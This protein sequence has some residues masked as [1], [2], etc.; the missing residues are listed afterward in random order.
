MTDLIL[1]HYPQSP[2]SEKVRIV[3][4][5]KQLV[6][7]SVEIP[8]LLPKPDLVV[9]TGGYRRTPVLQ[10][11]ADIYCDTQCI[12]RE[13][14]RRFPE[15]TLFPDGNES[16][17]WMLSRWIDDSLL[18]L[19]LALV[20][21]YEVEKMPPEFIADRGRLYFGPNHDLASFNKRL[22]DLESQL[23]PQLEWLQ[24]LLDGGSF[25]HGTA[26]GLV[27]AYVYFIVWFFR[28][29]YPAGEEILSRL[30]AL[31]KW[32]QNMRAFGHGSATELAADEAI[33][34]AKN[35]VSGVESYVDPDDPMGLQA[36]QAISVTPDGE[37]GD[38]S[39]YGDLARLDRHQ[40]A[41]SRRDPRID[42]VV[43]CFPRIGYRIDL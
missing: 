42:D 3:F 1:H 25:I 21:G 31:E 41:I 11:G 23:R 16:R 14:E 24:K 10:C 27:D 2:V 29:R 18:K 35:A 28:A 13:L 19:V 30:P 15:P 37:G 38:P 5:I 7:R 9:L 33:S 17:A 36:G 32:E 20:L 12:I 39:V 8:R 26:P 40:I 22:P 4:G 43:V 34:I 6:W